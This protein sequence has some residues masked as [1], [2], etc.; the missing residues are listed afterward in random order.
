MITAAAARLTARAS[1]GWR[2]R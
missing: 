1:S 2:L